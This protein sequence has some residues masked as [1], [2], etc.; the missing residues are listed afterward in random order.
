MANTNT[1]E[2]F[3]RFDFV[4]NV[5]IF[6]G[7][8]A[9]IFVLSVVYLAVRGINYGIDFKG[10]TEIQ[11]KFSQPV[12]ID[13]IRKTVDPLHLGEVGVQGIG[14]GSEYII[15]FVGEK[16]ANDK[17]TNEKLNEAIGRVKDAITKQYAS[18]GADIRRVDT[19][20]PQV[21]A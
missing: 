4:K 21:G 15:R 1:T 12:H 14:E 18:A 2:S 5:G 17:E 6:G 8:S 9:A 7:I 19:V 3:G 13:E 16:G 11:V 10:G 20:G